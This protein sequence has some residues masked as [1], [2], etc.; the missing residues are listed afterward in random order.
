MID[1]FAELRRRHVVGAGVICAIAVCFGAQAQTANP[2]IPNFAPDDHTSWYP[3]RP[4]GDNFLPPESGAGPIM[5]VK[6]IPYV[7]NGGGRG[8]QYQNDFASTHPTY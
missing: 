2:P 7:P 1:V 5:Q 6:D 4:D 8:S 3:D